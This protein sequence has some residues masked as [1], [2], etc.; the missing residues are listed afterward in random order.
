MPM[1]AARDAVTAY[2]AGSPSLQSGP[3]VLLVGVGARHAVGAGDAD[4]GVVAASV[5]SGSAG[6]VAA[7]RR[8][9][10]RLVVVFSGADQQALDPV[11]LLRYGVRAMLD[12]AAPI[13][14]I[15]RAIDAAAAGAVWVEPALWQRLLAGSIANADSREVLD[16]LTAKELETLRLVAGG[17]SNAQIA[18]RQTVTVKTVKF[19]ISNLLHKLGQT[20]R[21]ELVALAHRCGLAS[22]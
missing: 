7:G 22:G 5:L 10:P 1:G 4:V 18:A 13:S 11:V 17:L 12:T 19:H 6:P 16:A 8:R 20:R 15:G 9:V 3:M 21:A 2:L 14:H